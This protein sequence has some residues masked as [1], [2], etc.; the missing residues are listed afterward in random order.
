M[1]RSGTALQVTYEAVQG[2]ADHLACLCAPR[3]LPLSPL[4]GPRSTPLL[5]PLLL[6]VVACFVPVKSKESDNRQDHSLNARARTRQ[7]HLLV[8]PRL[9]DVIWHATSGREAPYASRAGIRASHLGGRALPAPETLH[10]SKWDRTA[11]C[12]CA[13]VCVCVCVCV[14]VCVC[15]RTRQHI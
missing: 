12:V 3:S 9:E 1:L 15:E 13:C 2:P 7:G 4:W 6:V 14:A 5:G 8:P 10:L 11:V